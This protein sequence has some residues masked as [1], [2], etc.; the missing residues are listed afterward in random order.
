MKKISIPSYL[1]IVFILLISLLV[2][3]W[4]SLFSFS[5]FVIEPMCA[6]KALILDKSLKT[7]SDHLVLDIRLPRALI[8]ALCGASLG[9][10][11][12]IMQGI[13]NNPLAS[14][15]I[16]GIN[17]GAVL[18][19]A[20]VSTLVPWFGLFGTGTAAFLGG[21]VTWLIV[22][23]IGKSWQCGNKN[24][25]L[26]LAG[27]AISALCTALTKALMILEEGQAIGI[28]I[29]LSGT[30]ADSRWDD[31]SYLLPCSIIGIFG[32]IFISPK[33]NLLHLGD[34]YATSLGVSPKKYQIIGS[35]LVLVIVSGIVTTVGA[36]GFVAVLIPHMA[37]FI[38]GV[39]HR[40]FIPIAML[41]GA[42]LVV[43][44]DVLSRA[45][46]FPMETPAGAILALIGTP[47]FIYLVRKKV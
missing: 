28:M 39:D 18:G 36:I 26:V 21:A 20:F 1:F 44:A 5:T 30:F 43:L 29:W 9:A 2:L 19:I 10:A 34:E 24:T 31:F 11:G 27:V 16:L 4:I 17:S 47:F 38:V 3:L 41:L 45:I 32:A 22:M 14:P 23:I 42:C 15:S 7:I 37:R 13:T 6:L 40:I 33:L 25:R 8:A 35:I 12:S 46:I